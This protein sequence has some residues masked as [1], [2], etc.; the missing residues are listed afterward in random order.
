MPEV[1][2]DSKR[3]MELERNTRMLEALQQGGVDNWEW[4]G[5]S[6]KEF[7]KEEELDDLLEQYTNEILEV[8]SLEA[9]VEYPAGR[10]CGHSI[11][12]NADAESSV[13]GLLHKFM[14]EVL[15]SVE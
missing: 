12:F 6:L 7:R 5:E 8:C 2:I 4:Y 9:D 3:L 15:E 11:L 1:K 10:E 13:Q 14:K